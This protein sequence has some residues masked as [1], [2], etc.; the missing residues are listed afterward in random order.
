MVRMVKMGIGFLSFQLKCKSL[1]DNEGQL[2]DRGE[3]LLEKR[4]VVGKRP[5]FVG[6]GVDNLAWLL[7]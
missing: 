3:C 7:E 4:P 6:V 5:C 2:S 1:S